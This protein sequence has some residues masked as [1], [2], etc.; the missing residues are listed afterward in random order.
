MSTE[1]LVE[2]EL[3][4]ETEV[5]G[6]NLPQCYFVDHKFHTTTWDRTRAAAVGSR[7]LTP[8]AMAR[9]F[10]TNT[11]LHISLLLT[12]L[13]PACPGM[14]CNSKNL[15]VN[16][17]LCLCRPTMPWT[18]VSEVKVKLHTSFFR[19]ESGLLHI[20]AALPLLPLKRRLVYHRLWWRGNN[21]VKQSC[22]CG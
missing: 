1:N 20:P 18:C 16:F 15:K 9:H 19:K 7:R 8:W 17:P 14:W 5:L 13:L 22:P 11:S 12:C 3:A 6:E 2:W 21:P 4:G 10:R